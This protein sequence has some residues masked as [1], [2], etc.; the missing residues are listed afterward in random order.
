MLQRENVLLLAS[1]E[2]LYGLCAFPFEVWQTV[3]DCTWGAEKT[4]L[5]NK[6]R[7][8]SP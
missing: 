4:E 2:N 7:K 6:E 8:T 1:L 3:F 5:N